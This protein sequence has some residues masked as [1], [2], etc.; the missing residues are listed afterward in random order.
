[1]VR[2][3]TALHLGLTIPY[4]LITV[5]FFNVIPLADIRRNA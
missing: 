4:P 1:M 2:V 5:P 3:K